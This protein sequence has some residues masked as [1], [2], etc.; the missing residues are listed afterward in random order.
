MI[1]IYC[2]A[3][4]ERMHDHQ[5]T[6]EASYSL[7]AAEGIGRVRVP[8]KIAVDVSKPAGER[9]DH[10]CW[11]CLAFVVQA[12]LPEPEKADDDAAGSSPAASG[13]AAP[14]GDDGG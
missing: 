14:E 12:L 7:D 5:A 10:L 8:V 3:C 2:D 6:Y 1:R 4:G 9:P 13:V 11:T